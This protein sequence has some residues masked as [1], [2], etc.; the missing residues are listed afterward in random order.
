[1]LALAIALRM[2]TRLKESLPGLTYQHSFI[3]FTTIYDVF[4]VL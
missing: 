4:Y 2:E 1:M 3:N